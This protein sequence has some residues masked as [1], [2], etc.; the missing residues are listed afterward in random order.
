MPR[1]SP[2]LALLALLFVACQAEPPP[3]E[4]TPSL[5]AERLPPPTSDPSHGA[6]VA[7]MGAAPGSAALPPGQGTMPNDEVHAPLRRGAAAARP[8]GHPTTLPPGH[9]TTLPPGHPPTSGQPTGATLPPGHPP[10]SGQPAG[11]DLATVHG[12]GAPSAASREAESTGER[13]LLLTGP[14]SLGELE[15]RAAL[16]T[17]DEARGQLDRAFRLVFTVRRELRDYPTAGQIARPLA[18]SDDAPT[19]ALAERILGYVAVNN[20][21][22]VASAVAHY[23]RAI[24]LAPDY[25]DAHYALAFMYTMNEPALGRTHFERAMELGVADAFGLGAQF[26]A[27]P[28]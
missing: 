21:F 26:G 27:V 25:G 2:A 5:V 6:G 18:A 13:P 8:P 9:P 3:A 17:S 12:G 19:A 15:P 4:E 11:A 24:E 22:D 23:R 7:G 20:G 10:T 1:C 14:G 28:K 16:V